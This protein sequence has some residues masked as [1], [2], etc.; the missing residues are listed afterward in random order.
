MTDSPATTFAPAAPEYVAELEQLDMDHLVHPHQVLGHPVKPLIMARGEGAR[1]WDVEGNAYIDGTCGLWQCAVGHGHPELIRAASAQMEQL[2][3]YASFWDLSNEPAIRLGERLTQ[4]AGPAYGH[5][6]LTSGGS[7][8]NAFA[9]KL[10]RLA[11]NK[12][13]QP[14]RNVILSRRGG[15]HGSG[16]GPS[17]AATG[18]PPLHDGFGPLPEGFVHIATPQAGH[19]EGGD[20]DAL[21]ADLEQTIDRIGPDKI[22]AFIGEPIM[23]V[24]GVIIPPEGYW[25]RVQELL[26]KHGI[27]FIFDEVVTAYG[28]L[29]CWFATERFDVQPDMIV[30]AK[31]ITSGYF[32]FGAVLIGD[33]PMELLDGQVLRHGFTYNAHPVGAAVALA[34]LEVIE[35]DGLLERVRE[36]GSVLGAL[37]HELAA[38][39]AVAEIRGEGLMWAIELAD[40]GADAVVLAREIRDRGVIVRGMGPRMT[41]SPPFVIELGDVERLVETVDAVINA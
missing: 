27:L 19:P 32:P 26:R 24:A 17:L 31:A 2:P 30:T 5:V 34:N 37:L 14:Q 38:T 25:P 41:I 15:Y 39:D 12:S 33:R 23:G 10:A 21:I 35:R 11:F 7:E 6:H 28:R 9:I 29:G 4:L 22:A 20:V 8:G 40:P 16:A 1:V 18:M 13:G 3:F 36:T